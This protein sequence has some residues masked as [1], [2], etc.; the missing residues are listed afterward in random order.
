MTAMA[1]NCRNVIRRIITSPDVVC[2]SWGLST[3]AFYLGWSDRGNHH[4]QAK[5]RFARSQGVEHR[6][7]YGR[8]G[9]DAFNSTTGFRCAILAGFP[10]KRTSTS[11]R[12]VVTD[13]F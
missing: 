2:L 1:M 9:T 10:L 7:D 5:V 3:G 8:G 6:F 4:A 12:Y 11:S 13:L